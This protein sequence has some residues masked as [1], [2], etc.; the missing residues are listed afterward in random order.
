MLP[1]YE[2]KF[3]HSQSIV[4]FSIHIIHMVRRR[5]RVMPKVKAKVMH[6]PGVMETKKKVVTKATNA[7][8]SMA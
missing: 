3:V 8:L 6:I 1:T 4:M 2:T 5:P 7:L